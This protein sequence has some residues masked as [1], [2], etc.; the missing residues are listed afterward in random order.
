MESTASK[1]QQGSKRRPMEAILPAE[2]KSR[3][4]AV[5][6]DDLGSFRDWYM[7][8]PQLKVDIIRQGVSVDDVRR[9]ASRMNVSTYK[10]VTMVHVP[11][12]TLSRKGKAQEPLT[13]EQSERVLGLTALIGMVEE[14]VEDS[15]DPTGFDAPTWVSNWLEQR[16][17]ALGGRKPVEYL[18]TIVGQEMLCKLLR[19]A[20]GGVFA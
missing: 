18:D 8:E 5:T 16:L 9:I 12:S 10:L 3:A 2:G 17:P 15:G 19:Q 14:M 4:S 7:T 13:P 1:T 11:S 6:L 20:Q